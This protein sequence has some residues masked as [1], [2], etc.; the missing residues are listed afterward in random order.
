[1]TSIYNILNKTRVLFFIYKIMLVLFVA[2]FLSCEG[3]LD[4]KPLD[5]YSDALVW[6]D[7]TLI[8]M[9][10]SSTYRAIPSFGSLPS[11][12]SCF[13]DEM[14][15]IGDGFD[16]QFNAGQATP[17]N[18]IGSPLNYW[19]TYFSIIRRCNIFLVEI[20]KSTIDEA[21]KTRMTGEI[22]VIRAW[23]Y[24]NLINL[25]G[26]VPLIKKPLTLADDLHLPR[27]TYDEC[28][29]LVLTDLDEAAAVLP[30][31][32]AA[33]DMGR[34]TKGAALAIKSRA[35]LYAASPL[36]NPTNDLTK[37]QK[38]SDAAKAVIDLGVYSLYND[39]KS[40][41][42]A[43]ASY[44]SE[45]IW[46][47]PFNNI[48][49]FEIA[50]E[51]ALYPGGYNGRSQLH[52]IH[53][54]VADY[55]MKNGLLPANDPAYDPQNP[56]VNRDPRFYASILYEGALFKG[57]AVQVYVPFGLDGDQPSGGAIN[58]T[59]PG[60]FLRKYMDENITD[61][62]DTR[63]G[64][65]PWT[66]FRLGEIYLNYAEA[67]YYLGN[68]VVC[69]EYINKIRSRTGVLMPAVTETGANLLKR[70]QNER[71]IE[72]A[73]EGHRFF[74][75][76]R[77]KIAPVVLNI[78]TKKMLVQKNA[79]TGV[80]SFSVIDLLPARAFF[81]KNYRLPIPQTEIDKNTNPGF[82]QNTGY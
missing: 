61:P 15:V 75:V 82:T 59:R 26:G 44:N 58:V 43:S 18:I 45:I 16:S 67:N 66:F 63:I 81:D 42:L 46:Q 12:L 22:K 24:H 19:P 47:R 39:Y 48:V 1:M 69:R 35:L 29:A 33:A 52:P 34:L 70:L 10:V 51:S 77:W 25:Y 60:Y 14:E 8:S 30:L 31:T 49:D 4:K 20:Q 79:T 72:L 9:F 50:V 32:Y 23:S 74:D 40:L 55:E 57:R 78:N 56:Y 65:T 21:L 54:I 76:R 64:N 28:L 71:R 68:E 80:I 6:Q 27:N 73:F 41:F 13:T 11:H 2:S 36:N 7:P 62:I 5:K 37:W 53:N 17:S 38:A 3:V